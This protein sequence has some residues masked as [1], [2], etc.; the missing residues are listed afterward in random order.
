MFFRQPFFSDIFCWLRL[1]NSMDLL[2]THFFVAHCGFYCC[3]CCCLM[4]LMIFFSI[5][6]LFLFSFS[7]SSCSRSVGCRSF[8]VSSESIR[9]TRFSSRSYCTFS[10]YFVTHPLHLPV[11]LP[12][13][14]SLTYL[15]H[16]YSH[17]FST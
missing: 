6:L 16:C 13:I 17:I 3:S 15:L 14:L 2:S 4:I 5:R 7:F 1:K 10:I 9:G 11:T 8:C 12:P